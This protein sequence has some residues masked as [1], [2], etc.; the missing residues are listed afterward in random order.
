MFKGNIKKTILSLGI[1]FAIVIVS[2]LLSSGT[3][4]DLQPFIDKGQNIT[5]ATSKKVGAGLYTFY[6]LAIFAIVAMALSGLK[7][8][9]K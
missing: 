1:F 6:A 8:I 2:Y 3:D 5:E 4:L 7:K 9:I